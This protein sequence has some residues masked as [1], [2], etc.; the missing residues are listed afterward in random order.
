MQQI[1]VIPLNRGT[2]E[3]ANRAT[4]QKRFQNPCHIDVTQK[5]RPPYKSEGSPAKP[6]PTVRHVTRIRLSG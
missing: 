2:R 4:K 1:D 5:Q 3:K 6:E